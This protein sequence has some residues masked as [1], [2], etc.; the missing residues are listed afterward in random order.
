MG[1]LC[2]LDGGHPIERLRSLGAQSRSGSTDERRE[3]GRV[4]LRFA[5]PPPCRW[6]PPIKLQTDLFG[7][8][9]AAVEAPPASPAP[10]SS[11]RRILALP[12]GF[13]D[14]SNK[15][16]RRLGARPVIM[17]GEQLVC[18]GAA[19]VHCEQ[20]CFRSSAIPAATY[21]DDDYQWDL[22]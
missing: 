22:E 13:L 10:A 18:R 5:G 2:C 7:A 14:A 17:G 11:G 21:S 1:R 12:C 19:M 9:E 3:M 15:P 16:C 6:R 20:D 4:G 8:P